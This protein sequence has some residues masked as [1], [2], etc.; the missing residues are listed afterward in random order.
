MEG[1]DEESVF[2]LV[3]DPCTV[4]FAK[5]ISFEERN[6]YFKA[7]KLCCLTHTVHHVYIRP[8]RPLMCVFVF[9]QM[10]ILSH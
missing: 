10:F 3:K 7:K 1:M 8:P 2:L 4:S 9:V 6:R 5:G